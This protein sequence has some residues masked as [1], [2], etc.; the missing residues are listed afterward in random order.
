MEYKV[1][2]SKS[3]PSNSRLGT[4]WFRSPRVRQTWFSAWLCCLDPM[5]VGKFIC[6]SRCLHSSSATRKK[7]VSSAA[8]TVDV[9]PHHSLGPPEF[10]CHCKHFRHRSGLSLSMPVSGYLFWL[11]IFSGTMGTCSAASRQIP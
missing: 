7:A 1:Y 9:L 5:W 10:I 4:G 11:W 8:D 3:F 2:A 6:S